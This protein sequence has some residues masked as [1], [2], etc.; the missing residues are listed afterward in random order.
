M[1]QFHRSL[2]RKLVTGGVA[3][4]VAM[5]LAVTALVTGV[6]T[7][8]SASTATS[9]TASA[10]SSKHAPDPGMVKFR[11]ALKA[12]RALTGQARIDAI[13]KVRADATAGKYGPR[14]EKWV[15][16]HSRRPDVWGN[17]PKAMRADL[18]AA[19]KA[20]PALRP[21][22]LHAIFVKALA[23]GYGKKMEK[24]AQELKSLVDG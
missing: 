19:R 22:K 23:G 12:A 10:T 14:A 15:K 24:R 4:A 5:G 7:S 11:A 18:Q 17:V 21:A 6:G 13:K 9:Q 3:F 16:N 2:P 1:M 20:A 8:A